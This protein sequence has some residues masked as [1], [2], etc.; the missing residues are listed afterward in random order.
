MGKSSNSTWKR[1]ALWGLA[2]AGFV[3]SLAVTGVAIFSGVGAAVGL[4]LGVVF[5]LIVTSSV[6][7]AWAE[8]ASGM[9][10]SPDRQDP[11]IPILLIGAMAATC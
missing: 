2:G 6:A 1:Y 3:G 5:P 4:V 8:K 10:P 7:A 11:T 9:S